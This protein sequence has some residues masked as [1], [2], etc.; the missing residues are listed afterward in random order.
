MIR[1]GE[2]NRIS[3]EY[4]LVILQQIAYGSIAYCRE[5]H[6]LCKTILKL[7]FARVLYSM[8]VK[9]LLWVIL[10]NLVYRTVWGCFL[11]PLLNCVR[12][13]VLG[14]GLPTVI[15]VHWLEIT[16]KHSDTQFNA[17]FLNPI[18]AQVHTTGIDSYIVT[19]I[20]LGYVDMVP[21]IFA[22]FVGYSEHEKTTLLGFYALC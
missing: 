5:A 3:S 15:A 16:W 2:Y 13:R 12:A 17:L 18:S 9:E 19:F 7:T 10:I 1:I 11:I 6:L 21:K 14:G 20:L 8:G 4:V 22:E